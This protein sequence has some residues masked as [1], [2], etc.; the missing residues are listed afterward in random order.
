MT[1]K[2]SV[3]IRL[4]FGG[5]GPFGSVPWAPRSIACSWSGL[6]VGKPSDNGNGLYGAARATAGRR[7]GMRVDA[8]MLKEEYLEVGGGF[9]REIVCKR[10]KELRAV[11]GYGSYN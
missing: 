9:S 3:A 5:G 10:R 6:G 8:C 4:M 1:V 2:T 7:K 11:C